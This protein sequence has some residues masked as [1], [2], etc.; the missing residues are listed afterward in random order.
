MMAAIDLSLTFTKDFNCILVGGFNQICDE[1]L[2][3]TEKKQVQKLES[4]KQTITSMC[5]C[6]CVR[7]GAK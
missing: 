6:V 1:V 4:H 7:V 2:A 5:V 3:R